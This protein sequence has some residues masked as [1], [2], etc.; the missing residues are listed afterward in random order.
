MVTTFSC[1]ECDG[2]LHPAL[3]A[4]LPA[5]GVNCH[6]PCDMIFRHADHFGLAIPNLYDSQ[7]FS[8]LSALLKF[9]TSPCTMGQLLWQMYETLQI[10]IG[11][12]GE[13][14]T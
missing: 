9:G 7:G 4:V 12:P 14:P 10:E 13:L 2:I 1:K 8:H 5:L 3:H 11:L 6:F